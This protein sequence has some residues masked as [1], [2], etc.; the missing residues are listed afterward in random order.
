VEE[1]PQV[2]RGYNAL[3][4]EFALASAMIKARADADMTQEQVA[5]AMGTNASRDRPPRKWQS[6]PVYAYA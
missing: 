5:T 4:E 2:R 1:G 3:D 6:P